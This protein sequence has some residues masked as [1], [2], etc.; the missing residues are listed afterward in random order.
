MQVNWPGSIGGGAPIAMPMAG[1]DLRTA[2]R[3]AALA[4][5]MEWQRSAT[6]VASGSACAT[7]SP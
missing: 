5:S 2:S 7:A 6:W 4:F 3:K 1:I